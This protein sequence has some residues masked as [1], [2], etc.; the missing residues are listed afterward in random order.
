[1][2]KI[3]PKSLTYEEIKE[4]LEEAIEEHQSS[5]DY[6]ELDFNGPCNKDY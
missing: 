6:K 3:K 5:I 2:K 4:I 1:M